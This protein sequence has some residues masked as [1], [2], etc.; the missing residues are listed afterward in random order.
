MED[1][2]AYN[3]QWTDP[4]TKVVWKYELL[5]FPDTGEVEMVRILCPI[6]F[7]STNTRHHFVQISH[8]H[9][10]A[11]DVT[12]SYVDYLALDGIMSFPLDL[13]SRKW[14]GTVPS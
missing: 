1:K 10:M 11:I 9:A 6:P 3:V 4:R 5:Y 13:S 12:Q 2:F 8:L 14:Y 7:R